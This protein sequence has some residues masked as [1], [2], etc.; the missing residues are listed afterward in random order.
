MIIGKYHLRLLKK[1][2]FSKSTTWHHLK[3]LPE[4][5]FFENLSTFW[6]PHSHDAIKFTHFLCTY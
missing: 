4:T 6:E 3:S 1:I 5:M 2:F